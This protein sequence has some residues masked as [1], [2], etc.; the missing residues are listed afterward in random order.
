[1]IAITVE[2]NGNYIIIIIVVKNPVLSQNMLQD[3]IS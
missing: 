3:K 2:K 1:M